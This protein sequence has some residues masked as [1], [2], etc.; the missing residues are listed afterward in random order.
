MYFF[1]T[2]LTLKILIWKILSLTKFA[3]F[4]E[5]YKAEIYIQIFILFVFLVIKSCRVQSKTLKKLQI[6]ILKNK[7]IKSI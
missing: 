5:F 7:Q 6:K 1:K 4:V 3:Y 2:F